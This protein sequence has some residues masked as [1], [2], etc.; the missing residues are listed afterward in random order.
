[1]N[2]AGARS[3]SSDS[4]DP[5]ISTG[6]L[7]STAAGNGPF[8]VAI[9]LA[10]ALRLLA[11]LG[12]QPAM[13][14]GD[15]GEYVR[16][17]LHPFP[18]RLR[19]DGYGF[20]LWVFKPFHSFTAVTVLQHL[21]GLGIGLMVYALL[22][23][24][25]RLP[26]WGATLATVPVLFDAYQIQ[27]EHLV[28]ADVTCTFLIVAA[29][30]VVL[31]NPVLTWRIGVAVGMLLAAATLTRPVA[32]PL[33]LLTALFLLVRRAPQAII[34]LLGAFVLPLVSYA[35]WFQSWYGDFALTGSNGIFLYARTATFSDCAKIRPP[36][37]ES[38][39]CLPN[40]PSARP[41]A[42]PTVYIWTRQSPLRR[43]PHGIYSRRADALAG[44]FARRAILAQ[45]GGY[46]TAV[47]GDVLRTF[48][49]SR[50]DYPGRHEASEYRFRTSGMAP[51][52]Q[53]RPILEAYEHGDAGTRAIEPFAWLMRSYQQVVYLRGTMLGALLL[54]GLA[55]LAA[56]PATRLLRRRR[57]RAPLIKIAPQGEATEVTTE[58]TADKPTA[59]RWIDL[60]A[61]GLVWASAV[62]LLVVPPATADFDYRYVVPVVPLAS[63]AAAMA[64]PLLRRSPIS[65]RRKTDTTRKITRAKAVSPGDGGGRAD[66]GTAARSRTRQ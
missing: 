54:L 36:P 16:V 40:P 59:Q 55:G 10:G 7:R 1:V 51:L 14:F 49:W 27:L 48:R 56:S 64:V 22:R 46:L 57:A 39:L 63:L 6:R 35:L 17:A 61:L 18:H 24:R 29:L 58:G 34:G 9:A 42:A 52:R 41:D 62:V 4:S 21:M 23:R 66:G 38:L 28:M 31:W 33:V 26:G 32:L 53:H 30:T 43:R 65:P 2:T 5:R 15:S 20:L 60:A 44:R 25:T 19:P 8:A 13:W 50:E 3:L 37:P 11:V 12:Y 45:P 47:G